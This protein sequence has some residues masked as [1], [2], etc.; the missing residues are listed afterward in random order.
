MTRQNRTAL[1]RSIMFSVSLF[2]HSGPS[3]DLRT[4]TCLDLD[5]PSGPIFV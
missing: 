4:L 3:P 1:I 2:L 5:A